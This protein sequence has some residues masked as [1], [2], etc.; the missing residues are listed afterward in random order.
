MMPHNGI[1]PP[2]GD[3]LQGMLAHL[4]LPDVQIKAQEG[5][6]LVVGVVPDTASEGMLRNALERIAP[7]QLIWRIGSVDQITRDMQESLHDPALRVRYTGHR[8]FAVSGIAK[9]AGAARQTLEQIS[10]DLVPMVTRIALQFT[11]D[12]RMAPPSDVESLL[13]VDGLQYMVSSDGT[14]HFVDTHV[15]SNTPD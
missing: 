14:K 8:E 10:G 9:N 12:D 3:V 7:G 13:A 15:A 6:F 2:T 11:A 4:Q 5:R 1:V